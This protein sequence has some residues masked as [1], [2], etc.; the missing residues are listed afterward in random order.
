[1][2]QEPTAAVRFNCYGWSKSASSSESAGFGVGIPDQQPSFPGQVRGG[3]WLGVLRQRLGLDQIRSR[4][5]VYTS[6]IHDE[7]GRTG[8]HGVVDR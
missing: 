3:S 1:M 6:R 2:S 7:L 8:E 5:A 4:F